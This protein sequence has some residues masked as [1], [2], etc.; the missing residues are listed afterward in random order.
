MPQTQKTGAI[1]ARYSTDLQSDRSIEDQIAL[2][3]TWAERNG[4]RIVA[5]FHD[6]ARS[7][8]AMIGRDGIRDMLE[9]AR[10]GR[11]DVVV[12]EALDRLSRDIADLATIHKR[13]T[14]SRVEIQA[15]NDG[16]VDTVVVGLRGLIGQL[17]RED[18]AKK[19]RRGMSGRVRDGLSAG[20][21]TYGYT[22]GA[23]RGSLVIVEHEAAIV[24]E[25]F[26]RYAAGESAQAIAR[27]LNTRG[28]PPPRGAIWRS[29]TVKGAATKV[30]GI[31]RNGVYVG[32]LIWGRTETTKD[33][34][35]GR[36]SVRVRPESEWHHGDAPHLR[37]IDQDVWDAVQARLSDRRT[38]SDAAIRS[39]RLL[40]G[41]MRCGSCGG[42]V[43]MRAADYKGPRVGCS[44]NRDAGTCDHRRTYYLDRIEAAVLER[45][46]S[47]FSSP[48]VLKI[49]IDEYR[50]EVRRVT[51][52]SAR[53]RDKLAKE[54]ADAQ[55]RIERTTRL[56]IDGVIEEEEARAT[57]VAARAKRDEAAAR[58]ARLEEEIP[59]VELHPE[60]VAAFH[61]AIDTLAQRLGEGNPADAGLR[62]AFR[63][64]VE[65]V[66]V[67]PAERG[68]VDVEIRGRLSA[69][70]G[71]PDIIGAR[72]IGEP[73][74]NAPMIVTL[75]R[76]G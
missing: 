29:V 12:V 18:G 16:R 38:R 48:D 74:R 43:V 5:E 17:F 19:V 62:D 41:I 45:L 27:D 10:L 57:L 70:T 32:R 1:Y 76:V 8:G 69:L 14:F 24:R 67:H 36:M 40:S 47:L 72:R 60:A 75:G 33:P 3:R 53:E 51:A 64:L 11:F 15:V 61:R 49:Y 68:Q 2:C 66:I 46:R 9:A 20:G 54:V 71:A 50:E 56:V 21:R 42:A 35:S 37:I 58:L 28:I 26:D 23:T 25:I 22:P 65:G 30:G 31:L 13:L 34:E 4:I 55:A 7:G 63:V 73:M 44:V 39:P 52:G 59:V 6:R